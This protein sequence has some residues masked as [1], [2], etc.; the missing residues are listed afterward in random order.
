MYPSIHV[1]MF[2]LPQQGYSLR[3]S[4]CPVH[5]KV[6][7]RERRDPNSYER[8]YCSRHCHLL[9]EAKVTSRWYQWVPKIKATRKDVKEMN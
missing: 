4:G 3:L 9:A 7:C 5:Y 1:T 6:P 2:P 8:E